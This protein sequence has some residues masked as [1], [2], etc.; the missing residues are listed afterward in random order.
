LDPRLQR[1]VQRYGWDRAAAVYESAWERQLALAQERLL[2]LAGARPGERV[3][4]VACGTGLVTL[5]L[6]RQVGPEGS[7]LGTDLSEKMVEATR[8]RAA[9]AGLANVR[10]EHMGAEALGVEDGAFDLAVCSLGLMY[11]P[12]VALALREMR[13]ALRPGGRVAVLVWGRRAQCGWAEVFPIVDARVKSDVCPLFFQLGGEG[14]LERELARTGFGELR[15]ERLRCTLSFAGDDDVCAAVFEGG[16]VALAYARFDR[17]TRRAAETE[18]LASIAAH[19]R[20]G[21]YAIPGEF[22]LGTGV[23]MA[24]RDRP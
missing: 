8:H 4:D 24:P 11:V 19:R 5:P 22:V 20:D 3:L 13:R 10:A 9:A 6:A 23:R 7:V 12:D 15:V 14:V 21:G 16:P 1:R 2:A 17:S 18:F